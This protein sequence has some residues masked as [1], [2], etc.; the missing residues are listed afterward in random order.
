MKVSTVLYQEL[1]LCS[2]S[3][4]NTRLHTLC[5]F[6]ESSLTDQRVSVTYLGRGLKNLSKTTKKHDI[7]RADRLI[8]NH[9]L[10]FDRHAIYEYMAEKL[11]RKNKN[12]IILIDWSPINGSEIFQLL[13]AS[14]PMQGRSQVIYEKVFKESAL[15]SDSAHSAFLDELESVLPV[16]CQPIIVADA[17]YRGPWFKAIEAKNGYWVNRVR[18]R[19]SLSQDKENWQSSSQW[20]KQANIGKTKT[21]GKVYYSKTNK[22]ECQGV[23]FKRR[24][25]GR[26]VKKMRGG[27]SNRTIDKIHQ[28]DA[29]EPWLLVYRLPENVLNQPE[30]AVSMYN[31]RMQIEENFRDTKNGKLGMS[32]EYANSKSVMRFDNLLLIAA[33]AL[34]LLWCIGTIARIKGMQRSLQ[35][36]TVKNRA[37]LSIIYLARE[38]VTDD[39]YRI[40]I[41]E[42]EYMISDMSKIPVAASDLKG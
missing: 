13:R 38:V 34:F 10:H 29:N 12:P 5:K 15:N 18:G 23:L 21:L 26:F 33:L 27:A 7:K 8:G 1:Q 31:L 6:V 14:I 9:H 40:T 19:V 32:L 24:K 11:I 36:N 20:F 35:A 42:F 22:L 2:T 30:I 28:K 4:H 16:G 41:D 25:K 17:G 3:I 37:V 39:R